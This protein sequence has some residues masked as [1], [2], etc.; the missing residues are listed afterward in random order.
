ML[1]RKET[2]TIITPIPGFIPR[3]L[4]VDI[5]HSHS[6]VITLN[7][8]VLSHRPIPA[9]R[10]AAADEYYSTWYEITERIQYLPGLG[11]AGSGKIKFNGCFH[12]MPWGLQTHIYAPMNIDMRNRYRI[13]GNQPGIEPPEHPE[14]GLE[15]LGVPKDGL[16]L[17]EDVEIKCNITMMS[18]VKAETKKASKEMVGRM[19]KKAELLDAGILK[20]MFDNGQLK[21]INPA[22]RS[23]TATQGMLRQQSL[24]YGHG[25][26]GNMQNPASPAPS[27]AQPQQSP[28]HPQFSRPG[29][30]SSHGGYPQNPNDYQA[31]QTPPPQSQYA[32]PIPPKTQ[33][34]AM[35]L[36]GDYYYNPQSPNLQQSQP[37]PGY[38]P[39]QYRNSHLSTQSADPRWSHSQGSP[40]LSDPHRA[41]MGSVT[42]STGAI[43]SPQMTYTGFAAELPAHNETAEEHRAER[44]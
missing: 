38:A 1:K 5:L 42:S 15:Q 11:K 9:P 13:Q 7:P 34:F 32:P 37:S 28:V 19:I 8:L 29:T 12:D 4:A 27:H 44:R 26:P 40:N 41:S 35:E 43:G 18:F 20:G 10:N 31:Q 22:D 24:S 6:E 21:T 17:R 3:Q 25:G 16:Y 30:S 33:Q 2:L 36:P 14:I 23:N 39:N